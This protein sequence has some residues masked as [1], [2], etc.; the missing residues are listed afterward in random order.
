[1]VRFDRRILERTPAMGVNIDAMLDSDIQQFDSRA[2][3]GIRPAFCGTGAPDLVQNRRAPKGFSVA[4]PSR[5]TAR[6]V[7]TCIGKVGSTWP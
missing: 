5:M 4:R 1:M 3:H 6:V 7:R 2:C